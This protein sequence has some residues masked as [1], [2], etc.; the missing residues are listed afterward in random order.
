M[1]AGKQARQHSEQDTQH[2]ASYREQAT[3]R[4][5]ALSSLLGQQRI[6][7]GQGEEDSSTQLQQSLG[8]RVVGQLLN[9]RTSRTGPAPLVVQ[10]KLM[11]GQPNDRYEQEA[12]RVARQVVQRIHAPQGRH[13]E[14]ME[15]ETRVKLSPLVQRSGGATGGIK[16]SDEVAKGIVAARGSGRPLDKPVQRLMERAFAADFS[17]VRV[18]TDVQADRLSQSLGARAFTAGEDLFFKWEE[19]QPRSRNGQK[20]IAHEL[21]HVV[22]QRPDTI[23]N[24]CMVQRKL[25]VNNQEITDLA[26]E[27]DLDAVLDTRMLGD[28]RN[29][30]VVAEINSLIKD[31]VTEGRN[32]NNFT[33]IVEYAER[34][35]NNIEAQA[36]IEEDIEIID[37]ILEGSPFSALDNLSTYYNYARTAIGTGVGLTWKILNLVDEIIAPIGR[38]DSPR[39]RLYADAELRR[40]LTQVG[41]ILPPMEDGELIDLVYDTLPLALAEGLITEI[42]HFKYSKNGVEIIQLSNLMLRGVR[43][44]PQGTT[45]RIQGILHLLWALIYTGNF[46][47]H[48]DTV[49]TTAELKIQDSEEKGEATPTKISVEIQNLD[50]DFSERILPSIWAAIMSAVENFFNPFPFYEDEDEDVSF[51]S[52]AEIRTGIR[53]D[54]IKVSTE[55]YLGKARSRRRGPR[56]YKGEFKVN[57][58]GRIGMRIIGD[59]RQVTPRLDEGEK[60]DLTLAGGISRSDKERELIRIKQI[61]FSAV[62]RQE[63]TVVAEV[64]IAYRELFKLI[65]AVSRIFL[66]TSQSDRLRFIVNASLVRGRIDRRTI[67][68]TGEDGR[69]G[70]LDRLLRHILGMDAVGGRAEKATLEELIKALEELI[71]RKIE[72]AIAAPKS[73]KTF[74]F[75]DPA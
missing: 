62:N 73:L 59:P 49:S 22:Q 30:A 21:T 17:K 23:S 44:V 47:V 32:F 51:L 43:I 8:N 67:R 4:D 42:P 25:Y 20:L 16:A 48:A 75:R 74:D 24:P 10:P 36:D 3:E 26:D 65:P 14:A 31:D 13:Q 39:T 37:E 1:A 33:E 41:I 66:L 40:L 55:R 71:H 50:I 19:Y 9:P 7:T 15:E 54:Q 57:T 56:E 35:L 5:I 46:Q 72:E 45:W 12:D 61:Q 63:G 34:R 52:S 53:F 68:I 64:E 28:G 38:M 60:L 6:T 70:V 27:K 2:H 18:H 29:H 58:S 69:T 11:I